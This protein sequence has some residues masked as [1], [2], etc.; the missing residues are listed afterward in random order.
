MFEALAYM[1]SGPLAVASLV[2][3]YVDITQGWG[4]MDPWQRMR[5]H[6][7]AVVEIGRCWN[8]DLRLR[9]RAAVRVNGAGERHSVEANLAGLLGGALNRRRL[10]VVMFLEEP[11]PRRPVTC[12]LE[13]SRAAGRLLVNLNL[14]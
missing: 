5:R 7:S 1:A 3:V 11:T 6:G 13:R 4:G 9:V 2:S 12:Q 10:R 8:A 14:G